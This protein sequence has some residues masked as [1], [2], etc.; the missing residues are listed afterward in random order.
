[1]VEPASKAVGLDLGLTHFYTD[2]DGEEKENPRLLRRAEKALRRMGRR[3]SRKVKG[4]RNRAKARNRLGRKHLHVQRQRRDFAAK[5]ARALV[6]SNDVIAYED[7]RVANMVK[8]RHLSKSI[9]DAG[10]RVFIRWLEYLAHVYGKVAVAVPPQYTS[11]DCSR[12]GTLVKKTLSQ[13]THV[14]P[15]CGL[16]LGRDH[17]SA[18]TILSKG[19]VLLAQL[20]QGIAE[21]HAWGERS[22]YTPQETVVCKPAR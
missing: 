15:K 9:S 2:S 4:S 10:W 5:T 11:Q 7:L 1:T 12:C 18:V 21:S 13:R 19:L 6:M 20:P 3:V 14:C 22:L 17:N 8:N 16:V